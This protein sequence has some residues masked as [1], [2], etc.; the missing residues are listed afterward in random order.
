MGSIL[1][2]EIPIE[3]DYGLLYRFR[4]PI[5]K[6]PNK[7]NRAF[8][9]ITIC[10]CTRKSTSKFP[11]CIINNNPLVRATGYGMVCDLFEFG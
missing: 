3:D 10:C 2:V 9:K 11:V 1:I 6:M 4:F 5:V 8:A 7:Y